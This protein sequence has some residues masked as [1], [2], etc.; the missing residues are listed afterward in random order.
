MQNA[1]CRMQNEGADTSSVAFIPHSAFIIL[2]FPER[3]S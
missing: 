3:L 2:H 1:K